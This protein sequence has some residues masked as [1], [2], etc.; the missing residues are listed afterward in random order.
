MDSSKVLIDS[1]TRCPITSL[2]EGKLGCVKVTRLYW[3]P[4]N[5]QVIWVLSLKADG[6]LVNN[7]S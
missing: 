2:P 4:K 1:G 6:M 7:P 5:G 3:I